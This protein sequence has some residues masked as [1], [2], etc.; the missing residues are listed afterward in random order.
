MAR[1]E[2]ASEAL[3]ASEPPLTDLEGRCLVGYAVGN[4]REG[5][6]VKKLLIL[7]GAAVATLAIV[8]SAFA[9]T[10]DLTGVNFTVNDIFYTITGSFTPSGFQNSG[11]ASITIDEPMYSSTPVTFNGTLEVGVPANFIVVDGTQGGGI[12]INFSHVL[13]STADPLNNSDYSVIINLNL[14]EEEDLFLE[15]YQQLQLYFVPGAAD[16]EVAPLPSTISLLATGLGL[17]GFAACRRRKQT[18]PAT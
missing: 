17:L 16:P 4:H 15:G 9:T 6:K 11:T 7:V 2:R 8:P 3:P 12:I 18:A 5:V 13:G 14:A 1:C 10:Y